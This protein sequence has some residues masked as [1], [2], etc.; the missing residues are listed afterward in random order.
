MVEILT[1]KGQS[2][3]AIFFYH[4]SYLLMEYG[5]LFSI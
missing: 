4:S 5:D 1:S 3:M 2:A